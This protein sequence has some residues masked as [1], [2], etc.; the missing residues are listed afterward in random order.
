VLSC[1]CWIHFPHNFHLSTPHCHWITSVRHVHFHS[2]FWASFAFGRRT[3]F[4]QNKGQ[5]STQLISQD[6]L[7]LVIKSSTLEIWDTNFSIPTRPWSYL[8]LEGLLD[9]VL[10]SVVGWWGWGVGSARPAHWIPK[11]SFQ[12]GRPLNLCRVYLTPSGLA[13]ASS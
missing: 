4:S 1:R 12:C 6:Q 8:C 2:A 10:A 3:V 13:Y 11:Q 5:G 9:S 7:N